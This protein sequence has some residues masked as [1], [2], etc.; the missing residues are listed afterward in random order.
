MASPYLE[1]ALSNYGRKEICERL[2]ASIKNSHIE[3]DAIAVRG[4]SGLIIGPIVA[5]LFD[6]PLVVIRRD[7]ELDNH[8][9]H[10]SNIVEYNCCFN[11]YII[12]DDLVCSGKTVKTIIKNINKETDKEAD[13]VGVFLYER[14]CDP[15]IVRKTGIKIP[16]YLTHPDDLKEIEERKTIM[17]KPSRAKKI[18]DKRGQV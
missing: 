18:V 1:S 5:Y 17:K 16:V 9:C 7:N 6:K 14:H 15:E 2:I 11:T 8:N 10:G 13:C 12:L 4:A 3:F